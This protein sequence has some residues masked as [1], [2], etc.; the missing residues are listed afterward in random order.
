M[1]IE[2]QNPIKIIKEAVEKQFDVNLKQPTRLRNN[3]NARYI[4]FRL[5]KDFTFSTLYEIGNEVDRHHATVVQGLKQFDNIKF[6]NDR[7][8]LNPYQE[9]RDF[10]YD[11]LSVNKDEDSYI[12]MKELY[13]ENKI[14]KE[15]CK[16]LEEQLEK[17]N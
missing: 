10:L 12:T 16:L 13:D 3:T 5:C 7:Q 1:I 8:Y 14:L 4:Y 6:T 15:K 2:T 17:N 11:K 9:L